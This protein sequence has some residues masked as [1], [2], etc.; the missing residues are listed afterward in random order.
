MS[1]NLFRTMSSTVATQGLIANKS[2]GC[3]KKIVLCI[4]SFAYCI[5]FFPL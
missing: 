4:D 5:I 1:S 3:E 2:S